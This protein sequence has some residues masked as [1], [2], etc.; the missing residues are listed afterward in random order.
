MKSARYVACLGTLLLMAGLLTGCS[1]NKLEGDLGIKGAPDWVNKGTQVVDDKGGHVIHGVGMAPAMPDLSLQTSTA[2]DRAR[3]EVARVLNS[4]MHVVS[5]NYSAAAGTGKDQQVD[6]STS[7]Q[8]Q[9][10]T[11]QNLSGARILTHWPNPKDGSLWA[12]AELDLNQVKAS[13]AN[14]KDM[15]AGFRDYFNAH[16][17]NIFDSMPKGDH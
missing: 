15:N 1:S 16:A 8:I 5:Q 12:I 9:S 2:D 13:V 3:A 14:A 6:Q 10:I 4:F 17:D 7:R 11:D